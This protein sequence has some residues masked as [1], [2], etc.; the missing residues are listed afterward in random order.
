M[1]ACPMCQKELTEP[2]AKCPRCQA[3]LSLLADFVTDLQTLLDKADGHRKAGDLAAAVQAY[4]AVL[5]VDPS[6][7]MARAALGPALLAVR[8][9][10]RLEPAAN[11]TGYIAVVLAVA[12]VIAAFAAGLFVGRFV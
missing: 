3:D 10:A 6:N 8:T 7:A 12:A 11:P 1:L 2:A 5:D 4:L 9:A